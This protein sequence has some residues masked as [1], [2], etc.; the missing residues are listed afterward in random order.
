MKK[1]PWITTEVTYL[2][3][4]YGF[5]SVKELAVELNRTE[6]A[7]RMYA[8]RNLKVR[9]AKPHRSYQDVPLIKQMIYDGKHPSEIAK[10]L[11]TSTKAIYNRVHDGLQYDAFDYKMLLLNRKRVGRMPRVKRQKGVD[12]A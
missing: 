6:E 7:I 8:H 4:N 2:R 9:S 5:V 1:R 12:K 11:K 10:V 3:K